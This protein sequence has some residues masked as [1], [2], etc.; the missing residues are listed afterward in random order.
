MAQDGYLDLGGKYIDIGGVP[1][2]MM[3]VV[4]ISKGQPKVLEI[5][6]YGGDNWDGNEREWA[7]K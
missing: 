1:N 5:T 3:A 4:L 2:G 7:L 6:V